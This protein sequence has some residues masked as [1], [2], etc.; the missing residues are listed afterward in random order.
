MQRRSTSID[1]FLQVLGGLLIVFGLLA[2][3][4]AWPSKA[5]GLQGLSPLMISTAIGFAFSGLASGLLLIGFGTV[6][7]LLD[8]IR[9]QGDLA[10]AG[11]TKQAGPIET[12]EPPE[13]DEPTLTVAGKTF[14]TQA[15]ADAYRDL[16]R[17]VQR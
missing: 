6:V 8:E 16:I 15:D 2:A 4:I 13:E 7:R 11:A 14:S 12:P 1:S 3:A 5:H 10:L 17:M 9:A